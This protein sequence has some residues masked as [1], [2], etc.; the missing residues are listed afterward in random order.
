MTKKRYSRKNT[1]VTISIFYEQYQLNKFNFDPQYQRDYNIWGPDQKSFLIDS[2][3]KNFPMPPIFL[4]QK[5]DDSSGKTTYDVIDGKQRLTTIID[6]IENKILL[7]T[8]FGNDIYGAAELNNKS[9][10]EIKELA[11]NDESIKDFISEF[12]GYVISVEYIENPDFK[13]ADNIFDRLNR[14]G[15]RLNSEELRKANYYDTIMYSD[16]TKL[17]EDLEIKELLSHL[18]TN[19]LEDV[20]FITEIYLLVLTDSILDGS[21][22]KIDEYFK[23]HVDLI[24]QNSSDV[25][26]KKVKDLTKIVKSYN[27]DFEKYKIKGVSHLYA[28]FFLAYYLNKKNITVN[29]SFIDKLNDFYMD[30]RN[31]QNFEQTKIYHKSMQSASKYKYSRNKRV[32]ALFDFFDFI[33]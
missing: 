20:S 18:N 22:D 24:D 11:K 27:L 21:E 32:A 28:L 8:S 1:G 7:P 30:L 5:I 2:I 12:W 10:N 19:R 26:V 29:S 25:I 3:M 9:F 16:I 6:F 15:E 14:G 33:I 4:E 23:K 31:N 17:R 13:I